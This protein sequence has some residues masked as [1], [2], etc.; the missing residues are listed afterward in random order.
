M[1]DVLPHSYIARI[2]A[3]TNLIEVDP[4]ETKTIEPD[5]AVIHDRALSAISRGESAVATIEPVTRTLP[6]YE[7][8]KE[9]WIEIIHKPDNKLVAVAELLSPWN[10]AARAG[11]G[12]YLAKRLK[13]IRQAIHLIE[14]DL[15]LGG[16]RLPMADSLPA[17]DYFALISRTERRPKSDVYAWSLRDKLPPIPIP[18]LPGTPDVFVNMTAAFAAAYELGGYGA[19]IDYSKPVAA[20]IPEI[21]RQW[22]ADLAKTAKPG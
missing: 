12:D 20:P 6:M 16:L 10:K 15:L 4:T 14:L 7:E 5:V 11:R 3:T 19:Y 13:L 9:R 2:D 18:L 8:I 1:N 22:V 17:G 21:H